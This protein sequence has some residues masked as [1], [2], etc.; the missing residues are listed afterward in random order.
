M[1]ADSAL[2]QRRNSLWCA[3]AATYLATSMG[4]AI[5]LVLP[6]IALQ[7]AL[8]AAQVQWVIGGYLLARV[9]MLTLAGA[10]CDVFG[11][12]RIF[13]VGMALFSL[14]TLWCSL[15]Q[16]GDVLIAMRV[17]Q[18]AAAA[19]ISPSSLLVLRASVTPDRESRALSYWSI[20]GVA[21]QG[22]AP[23]VGGWLADRFGWASLFVFCALLSVLVLLFYLW[24]GDA[25]PARPHGPGNYRRLLRDIGVCV[26]LVALALLIGSNQFVLSMVLML[27]ALAGALTVMRGRLRQTA[28]LRSILARIPILATGLA[29][30]GVATTAMLWGAYFVQRDLSLS[31]LV[32]GMVCMPFAFL[33]VCSCLMADG[34]VVAQRYGLCFAIAALSMAAAAWAA[35]Q[36]EQWHSLYL[37]ATVMGLL[38]LAYGFINGALSAALL[39]TYPE[40]ESGDA[41]SM[42]SLARQFGQLIGVSAFAAYRDFSGQVSGSDERLF[43][44][45]VAGSVVVLAGA[46]LCGVSRLRPA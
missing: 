40:A 28:Y 41:A 3:I 43:L 16:D 33:G 44:I 6:I 9:G 34:L 4:S 14:L 36:A 29:G 2:H 45:L 19:L 35:F 27:A 5:S 21:G 32:Y 38:G 25:R 18:G 26:G 23:V 1:S 17:L 42:G 12:R 39:N 30:F 24:R 22:C 7:L 8:P 46:L 10:L 13:I 15:L 20:A 11:A 37:A 31:A